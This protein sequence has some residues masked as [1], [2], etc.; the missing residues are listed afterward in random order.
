M[1]TD[2]KMRVPRMSVRQKILLE[3]LTRS[4]VF[5]ADEY[6]KTL[7]F[8]RSD[9]ATLDE[10]TALIDRALKRIAERDAKRKAE[11]EKMKGGEKANGRFGKQPEP[12]RT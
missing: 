2:F 9:N 3:R 12:R 10:G 4:S 5:S 8:I 7:A 6:E 1:D 11:K